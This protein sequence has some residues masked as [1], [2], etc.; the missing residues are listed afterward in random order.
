MRLELN[1][2]LVNKLISKFAKIPNVNNLRVEI[3]DGFINLKGNYTVMPFGF[4]L[5]P[6]KTTGS[7]IQF[8]VEGLFSGFL[9]KISQ[10]GIKLENNMLEIDISEF[11]EDVEVKNITIQKGKISVEI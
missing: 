8:S 11:I 3:E 6:I 5:N 4:R 10:K 1:E 9:P 7:K 2:D